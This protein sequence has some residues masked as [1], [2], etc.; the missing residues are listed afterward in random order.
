MTETT[1][2]GAVFRT[3]PGTAA[4]RA[5]IHRLTAGLGTAQTDFTTDV[6]TGADAAQDNNNALFVSIINQILVALRDAG[7]IDETVTS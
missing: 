1:S 4:K 2:A 7:I 5:N 6:L 3:L